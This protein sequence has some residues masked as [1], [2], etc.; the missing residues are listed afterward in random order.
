MIQN[1]NALKAKTFEVLYTVE[2]REA[3]TQE[4]AVEVIKSEAEGLGEE[5]Y[6]YLFNYVV[7][8]VKNA[9][10]LLL[11]LNKYLNNWDIE[12]ISSVARIAMLMGI[13]DIIRCDCQKDGSLIGI[14]VATTLAKKYGGV[15]EANLVNGVLANFY[16]RN[17][18]D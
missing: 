1:L 11:E 5:E 12:R 10:S 15:E 13:T 2:Q 16:E 18:N 6:D 4:K 7:R 3:N 9:P 14:D 17:K 8:V